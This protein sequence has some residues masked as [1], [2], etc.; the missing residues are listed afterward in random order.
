MRRSLV[1]VG[2]IGA[3]T[4]GG[5]DP[6]RA[7]QYDVLELKTPEGFI[8]A[9]ASAI[10]AAGKVVGHAE[11]AGGMDRAVMWDETG[12][13]TLIPG[14]AGFSTVALNFTPQGAAVGWRYPGAQATQPQGFY[15]ATPTPFALSATNTSGKAVGFV[16]PMW[17]PV[18]F[19]QG[20]APQ[21]LSK[22]N[23]PVGF[24]TDINDAGL[25]V[26]F[27]GMSP[28]GDGLS[29]P[30]RWVSN[31]GQLLATP[32]VGQAWGVNNGGTIVGRVN[33]PPQH[34][35]AMWTSPAN[36]TILPT[37]AGRTG[38]MD[39]NDQGLIVGWSYDADGDARAVLF[40]SQNIFDLNDL[41]A[42][43]DT[44]VKHVATLK[45]LQPRTAG[46]AQ[47]PGQ[48]GSASAPPLPAQTVVWDLH[49]ASGINASGLIC[50]SGTK[51]GHLTAFVLKPRA[52]PFTA[53]TSMQLK[54]VLGAS[55]TKVGVHTEAKGVS[56]ATA[57]V[58]PAASAAP[59]TAPGPKPVQ[60]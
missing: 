37:L 5:A 54:S 50:G 45:G 57:S 41:V 26:G 34:R 35:A 2:L 33:L 38:A 3:V 52:L 22:A 13:P 8:A 55:R 10:N 21:V 18:V 28:S 23:M 47:V 56:L 31:A 12:H 15:A 7:E 19:T 42:R 29:K 51:N 27:V 59:T 53:V 1:F 46:Q 6:A 25:V 49:V 40:K 17:S 60:K 58:P 11:V 30:I 43:P 39:I 48:T 44:L 4:L 9:H 24:A 16:L 32:T 36:L 14:A 20:S